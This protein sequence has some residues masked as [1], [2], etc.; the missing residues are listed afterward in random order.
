MKFL[1]TDIARQKRFNLIFPLL[2]KEWNI[3]DLGCGSGWFTKKLRAIGYNCIGIDVKLNQK[4]PSKYLIKASAYKIPFPKDYFDCIV[5]M[6][7]LEHI[8]PSAYKEIRRVLKKNGLLVVTT[9]YPSSEIFLQIMR[10][11]KLIRWVTD[12]SP[13][14][15]NPIK[16]EDMPFRLIEK[17]RLLIFDQYAIFKNKK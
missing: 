16:V 11:L 13:Q 17:R 10:R 2:K 8:K 6:E 5:A 3:L 1:L 7:S 9:P 15:I 12:D 14:H 4:R